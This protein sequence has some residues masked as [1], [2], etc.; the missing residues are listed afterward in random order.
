MIERE[1]A[2]KILNQQLDLISEIKNK[3]ALGSEFKKWKRDTEIAIQKIFGKDTRHIKDFTDI[4]YHFATTHTQSKKNERFRRGLDNA[5]SILQSFIDELI[6]YPD[7]E[8][9]S[10][11]RDS[12][13]II[14]RICIR[15]HR[16]ARQ[17][18][19]RHDDRSPL[20]IEDEYDVQDLL[21][22]LL[23]LEFDD[24]RKEE[25]TPSYAGKSARMDFLLKQE[26]VVIEIK[27]THKNLGTKEI[28]EQLVIDQEWYKEHPDCKTLICFVYDPEAR[29]AN[30]RGVENDLNSTKDGFIFKVIITP[31]D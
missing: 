11:K 26:Q 16:V 9:N 10:P 2:L 29:I 17:L 23:H 21:H 1:K 13:T 8:L 25:Y 12:I 20:D 30:P 27:K 3:P 5:G 24:I 22:A 28:S 19:S 7:D 15:F 6:L 4:K 31:R 14:E 18:R